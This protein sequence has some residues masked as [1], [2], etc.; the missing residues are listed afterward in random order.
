MPGKQHEKAKGKI[1]NS[2]ELDK[3][4]W[5]ELENKCRLEKILVEKGGMTKHSCVVCRQEDQ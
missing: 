3:I 4:V 2:E 5:E 1:M